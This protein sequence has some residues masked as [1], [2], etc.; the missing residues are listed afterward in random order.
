MSDLPAILPD[1][2]IASKAMIPAL[3]VDDARMGADITKMVATLRAREAL[4]QALQIRIARLEKQKF[5][6]SSARTLRE[7]GQLEPA[8]EHPEIAGAATISMIAPDDDAEPGEEEQA[9]A[10]PTPRRRKPLV[11][12]GTP[13]ERIVPDPGDDCP[14]C[15][16][17]L[18]LVGEDVSGILEPI[19]AGL[20]PI[21]TARLKKSCVRRVNDPPDRS[22]SLLTCE[23]I[24]RLPAPSRRSAGKLSPRQ[25]PDPPYSAQHGRPGSAGTCSG[26]E[27]RRSPCAPSPNPSPER[28]PCPDGRKH[29]GLDPRRS[30]RPGCAGADPAGRTHP[31][32]YPG[33]GP[34]AC[35]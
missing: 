28:D 15:G 22:L 7:I 5:G 6:T 31:R 8:L 13:R 26:V 9:A 3:Q 19:S 20:K 25:F 34:P 27:V 23:K 24:T 2:P 35:G 14:H 16:G 12:E 17:T 1:D 32:R 21:G 11:A 10:P 33:L 18:R 30:V 4:V 29:S